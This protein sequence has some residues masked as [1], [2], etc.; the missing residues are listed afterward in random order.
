MDR[1]DLG[2]QFL[3]AIRTGTDWENVGYISIIVC[4]IVMLIDV[5]SAKLRRKLIN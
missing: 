3:V 5:T 4:M 2:L 1:G